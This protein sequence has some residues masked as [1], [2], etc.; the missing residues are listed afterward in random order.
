M[1]FIGDVHGKYRQYKAIIKGCE[2]SIQ[3]GDMGVGF[4]KRGPDGAPLALANPPF[5]A[6]YPNHRFIRGNHDNPA[7]CKRQ[8]LWIPDGTV[9]GDMMFIGGAWSIDRAWRTEG[10]DWWADE[11]LSYQELSTLIDVYLAAKPRIMVT[12]DCP[13][14]TQQH[15][16]SHHIENTRTNGAFQSMFELHQPELWIFGHHHTSFRRVING[17]QFI[18]L[19]ELEYIDLDI[20]SQNVTPEK[21]M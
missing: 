7:V 9:E 4:Y 11:E 14:V 20:C 12:H 6:M 3:V 21:D 1:R 15:I 18:C 10:F 8:H 19:N 17:T 5:D 13:K 16:H 2:R